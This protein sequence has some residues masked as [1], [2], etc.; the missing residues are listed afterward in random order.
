MPSVC[1]I[2]CELGVAR[3]VTSSSPQNRNGKILAASSFG[4]SLVFVSS[5]VIN[6]ALAAIG[7]DLSLSAHVLQWILNAELLPLAALTLVGGA[8]GD[9][10]GQKQIFL[11]GIFLFG[12]GSLTSAFAHNGAELVSSRFLQG[13]GEALILPTGITILGRAFPPERKA[14]AVGIWSAVAAVASSIAPA[15]AGLILDHGSWR[16]AFL[17][18]IPIAGVAFVL[19][20]AWTPRAKLCPDVPIDLAATALSVVSLG[21]L[22]WL[23]MALT[24]GAGRLF[25]FAVGAPA[26]ILGFVALIGVEL[27]KGERAM[28][29]P[30]LFAAR[31][32]IALSFFTATLYGAFTATLTLVPFVMIKSAHLS[33]LLAGVAF[34]PLQI[35]IT[36]VSPLAGVLCARFG[37]SLPLAVGALVT[38]LGCAAALKI[39]VTA[40]YWADIFPAVGLVAV[41]MSLVVAP[42]TTLVLTSVD[43]LH[44]ATAS[45]FNGA[46]SRVGSLSAI[47]LVGGVLQKSGG[48]LI[49]G[50][51]MAMVASAAACVIAA[52]AALSIPPAPD[53]D[54]LF[55]L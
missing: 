52:L 50:F 38:G 37:H 31:S 19:A 22:G 18:Q 9:R 8:L 17:M 1:Q 40:H 42:M 7:R 41:G 33:A 14:W 3:A 32:V 10:Y 20:V 46:V 43:T 26:T 34:I 23:L 36:A 55:G 54:P 49:R 45:G 4:C 13:V 51:H 11:S 29:P 27:R 15:L 47:A 6:V 16:G 44:A 21:T 53:P 39:N 48:D 5:A 35:L 25:V 30:A 2:G 24:N 28:L 12:V